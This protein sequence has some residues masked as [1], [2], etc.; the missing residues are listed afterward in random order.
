MGLGQP[1][2]A[3]AGATICGARDQI[4]GAVTGRFGET[5]RSW[6]MGPG[7]RIIEVFASEETGTWT[8]TITAPDGRTCLVAAGQYWEDLAPIPA[9]DAI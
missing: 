8:I 5:P 9:G 6:G 1:V 2:N 7:N 3:Q 4:I